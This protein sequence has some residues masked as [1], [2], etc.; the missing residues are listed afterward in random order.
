MDDDELVI[1]STS[2]YGIEITFFSFFPSAHQTSGND[3]SHNYKT[4]P[5]MMLYSLRLF[6]I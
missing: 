4:L 1:A 2:I 5:D 3:D 6:A